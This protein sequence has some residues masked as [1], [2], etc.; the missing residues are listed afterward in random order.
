MKARRSESVSGLSLTS[1]R[2]EN[3]ALPLFST[4]STVWAIRLKGRSVLS[5]LTCPRLTPASPVS[6][7]PGQSANAG[8]AGHDLDQGGGGAELAGQLADLFLGQEQQPVLFEKFAGAERL[9][10]FEILGVAGE[11]LRQRRSRRAGEFRRRRLDHGQ[12]GAFPVERLA[13]LIVA[14][15]PVQVG[16][17][18]RVDV[19]V[20][21]EV[22]GRVEARGD[23]E[24]EGDQDS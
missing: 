18:Q 23:R 3:V 16:R 12:D 1:S 2:Q 15:A 4:F 8:I 20:D 17:N 13:E 11:L 10:R 24:H 19:G 22:A 21:G 7:A 9:N 6:S 14:L 5:S